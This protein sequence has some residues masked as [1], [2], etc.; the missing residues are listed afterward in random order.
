[1]YF[2]GLKTK[3]FEI[4]K[5]DWKLKLIILILKKTKIVLLKIKAEAYS[6]YQS[7]LI[8]RAKIIRIVILLTKTNRKLPNRSQI[9]KLLNIK[10]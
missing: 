4:I 1:M 3:S 5:K 9:K 10:T 6:A 8:K 2:L 7:T